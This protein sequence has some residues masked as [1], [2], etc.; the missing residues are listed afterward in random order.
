MRLTAFRKRLIEIK[1]TEE[2][3]MK[4]KK[5]LSIL[6]MCI[7]VC[8]FFVQICYSEQNDAEKYTETEL[9]MA[10]KGVESYTAW[11]TI[12][13]GGYDFYMNRYK[14]PAIAV[15]ERNLNDPG[16]VLERLSWRV[17]TFG[18]EQEAKYATS[19]IGYYETFLFNML[20][21]EEN[22]SFLSEFTGQFSSDIKTFQ[23]YEKLLGATATSSVANA[24][25]EM[26]CEWTLPE[27]LEEQEKF[28]ES[29]Q[30]AD[31]IK[32][33]LKITGDAKK[34]IGYAK[35]AT[36]LINRLA[37]LQSIINSSA[38]EGEILEDLSRNATDIPIQLALKEY[39]AYTKEAVT[40][41]IA[42]SI[43][44]GTVVGSEVLKSVS[45]NVFDKTLT[46]AG[47][48]GF[49]V[50]NA[51]QEVG[52]FIANTA[53]N[54]EAIMAS[55]Y[56]IDAMY[57]LE[58]L[59]QNQLKSYEKDFL[60]NPTEQKAQKFNTALK[61]YYKM[62]LESMDCYKEFVDAVY[63]KGMGKNF[64]CKDLSKD[65]YE[66]MKQEIESIK[67]SIRETM[68]S[69]RELA[70]TLY[71]E[72]LPEIDVEIDASQKPEKLAP[73]LTEEEKTI[74]FDNVESAVMPY[75]TSVIK[76]D[77]TLFSDMEVY[78]DVYLQSGTLSLNGH[79]LIVDGNLYQEG[80]EL[81]VR[82]GELEVDGSY[83]IAQVSENEVGEKQYGGA[84]AYLKM[85][86]AEDKVIVHGDFLTKSVYS[87]S[88]YLT[89]GTMYVAG[90]FIQKG[91]SSDNFN[92]TNQHKVV[93]NGTNSQ[94]IDIEKAT[95]GFAT[96]D[97]ENSSEI[98]VSGYFRANSL[99]TGL[100]KINLVSD[101]MNLTKVVLLND[102]DVKGDVHKT[103]TGSNTELNLQGNKLHIEG[104]LYQESGDILINKGNLDVDG[105]YYIAK[106]SENEVGEEQYGGADAY[107]KMMRAEDK[108][109]VHGDFLTKSVYIHSS[110]LTAGTMYVA[111]DF[112]QK[113]DSSRTNFDATNQHKVVLNGI[114]PQTVTFENYS[115]SHFN[116]LQ[117]T[118]ARS[119]YTFNPEPCWNEIQENVKVDPEFDN[120]LLGY[121]TC[122]DNAKW[123]VN[124]EGVLHIYGTGDTYNYDP[125]SKDNRV[126]TPWTNYAENITSVVIEEGITG[127]G[128]FIF[129]GLKNVTEIDI[130]KSVTH[131]GNGSFERMGLISIDIPDTVKEIGTA[132][133]SG[134]K[135][136]TQAKF[137]ISVT[138]I[139]ELTFSGC[140][141][142][143]GY[144][145]QK[146]ITTIGR[147]AFEGCDNLETIDLPEG[148]TK[149]SNHAF[150]AVD[151]ENSKEITR[152]TFPS[153]LQT[154]EYK[155]FQGCQLEEVVI[156]DS[157][158]EMESDIFRYCDKLK[159][160]KYPSNL[161]EFYGGFK[162][163]TSL[164][165]VDIPDSVRV[166]KMW[167]F[168]DIS[169]KLVELPDKLEK[170]E[171]SAFAGSKLE[172]II[173]PASVN[174]IEKGVFNE[175]ENLKRI[176]FNGS[177]PTVTGRIM[178]NR[179]HSLTNEVYY[180]AND[181]TWTEEVMNIMGP[182]ATWIPYGEKKPVAT[183]TCGENLTWQLEEDGTL[184]ISGKGN[185]RDFGYVKGVPW[186]K[187]ADQ[188][189]SAVLE[190]GVTSVGE[191]AF[192]GLKNMTGITLPEGVKTIGA[193]AFKNSVTLDNVVLPS[194]VSKIGESAFYG[195]SGMQKIQI[196]EGVYT[197]WA[198][199]FKNCTNLKEVVLPSTLI[200]LD[201]AA[202]YGC[203]SIQQ[204]DI[205]KNVS[206]IGV[207]CFKNCSNLS[208]INLPEALT[209]VR[210][211][212][213]YGTVI[214]EITIPQ[215]VKSIGNYAFKNCLKLQEIQLPDNLEKIG[216]S[217]FY[218]N[219][220]LAQLCI[221]DKVTEIGDYAFRKCTKLQSVEFSESL[222]T[223]GESSFYGCSSLEEVIL[224][225]CVI[226]IKG[227]AFKSCTALRN[228]TLSKNLEVLG[229]SAF[230]GCTGITN[231]EIPENVKSMGNYLFSNCSNLKTIIFKG[232][233]PEIADYTFSRVNAEV[234]Y[235]AND[236]TWSSE[237]LQ[238][239]GG[240][241]VW[242]SSEEQ[243][244]EAEETEAE[245]VS[246]EENEESQTED[247]IKE[248][249]VDKASDS[250]LNAEEENEQETINENTTDEDTMNK[251]NVQESKKEAEENDCLKEE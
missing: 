158:T 13:N 109:I 112:I 84:Y 139:P 87:H 88:S 16:Y 197:I 227:Y 65:Q 83:Y 116:I 50:I 26:G 45:K 28:G 236:E 245:E 52:K 123:I 85:M 14:S 89:A 36:D 211:A 196:P 170:I 32:G 218:G 80:G 126:R 79:K 49:A 190:N 154:I 33:A 221:P 100:E 119:Q 4:K 216:D 23:N 108:V 37:K 145:V 20:Y 40:P 234:F 58:T 179:E 156:P 99:K 237:V 198:Y 92:A 94:R 153:T 175:C 62:Q 134:C 205:P 159:T 239:Y 144:T 195:C 201:E 130:P 171:Q 202:F 44:T 96:L 107:L 182:D 208:T 19:E 249:T 127:I 60:A 98:T 110:Y 115:S 69:D 177:A 114:E 101:N 55:Q 125:N 223:I 187:Y 200:K 21:N 207:Y 118:R 104:N 42:D 217:A 186:Y 248:E 81:V 31:S 225:D 146:Q 137:P 91:D 124:N 22:D 228:V 77:L 165:K 5:I 86:C 53:F 90:D 231:I 230:Y 155:A 61:M 66:K 120:T 183:G 199:T 169:L 157:V 193:Y 224:P 181:A 163:C 229:D 136:L 70:I 6:I 191:Y 251:E 242:K 41:E 25:K 204:I 215:N 235:P 206:I 78:G 17:L 10:H 11:Y 74:V 72:I 149:I 129:C 140:T 189:T 128:N 82:K 152:I 8:S 56:K 30:K 151:R 132:L 54:T 167:A 9:K 143:K 103:S 67:N 185:M 226:T 131:I 95:S 2:K 7:L 113:G 212:A 168:Q 188:I 250:Q 162:G 1:N 102:V 173:I 3:R 64:F 172:D 150:D 161:V 214:P 73:V 39:S 75:S 194:T 160:I 48:Y 247:T 34:Y 174:T 57:K 24:Y 27:T 29:L 15:A 244:E 105:S 164:E 222:T 213:F 35:T 59:L 106:V 176:T 233:A 232:N 51:G 12:N 47:G 76:S 141:G 243:A 133:F 203:S 147:S 238:G 246:G 63:N 192:Y 210:E 184:T 241:L 68:Q 148:L 121:G 71:E 166:I 97:I 209:S 38:E 138:E 93:L 135:N 122:G 18:F 219:T 43:M 178:G 111:G 46:A 220:E 117:L 240:N 180:P 142:L